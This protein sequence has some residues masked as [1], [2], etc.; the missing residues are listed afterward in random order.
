[1]KLD[2]SLVPEGNS[3]KSAEF[4]PIFFARTNLPKEVMMFPDFP[5]DPQLSSFLPHQEVQNYLEQYCQEHNIRPHIRV[6]PRF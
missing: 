1:M 6:S 4:C 5:F 3:S 2:L